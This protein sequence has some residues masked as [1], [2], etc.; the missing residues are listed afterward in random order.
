LKKH[1]DEK[2]PLAFKDTPDLSSG[3]V[4][5]DSIDRLLDQLV[6]VF[7]H[8]PDAVSP[9]PPLAFDAHQAH[10]N[11]DQ[12]VLGGKCNN[13]LREQLLIFTHKVVSCAADERSLLE[14]AANEGFKPRV[15]TTNGV[16]LFK[17]G[18]DA[19]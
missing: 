17:V 12:R 10:Q 6:I 15:G 9:F 14:L 3:R 19:R 5:T 8:T 13:D 11:G 18:V 1:Y 7:I 4:E 2:Y 16:D